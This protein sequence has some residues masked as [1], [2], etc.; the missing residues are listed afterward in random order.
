LVQVRHGPLQL[1]QRPSH[2][3][4]LVLLLLRLR[5][6]LLR[7]RL[8]LLRLRLR[9]LLFHRGLVWLRYHHTPACAMVLAAIAFLGPWLH[10]V[11]MSLRC[12]RRCQRCA[13]RR[14]PARVPAA[15]R[16]G[17][18]RLCSCCRH[19]GAIQRCALL[20]LQL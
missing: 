1:L 13:A 5:L 17:R 18:R 7:L 20:R 15:V 2:P 6:R 9:L 10:G 19:N 14:M 11:N 8:R 12:R 16:A 3:R 4:L